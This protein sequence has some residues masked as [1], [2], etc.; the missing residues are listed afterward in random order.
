MSNRYRRHERER[1]GAERTPKQE[2]AP[3]NWYPQLQNGCS[4]FRSAWVTIQWAKSVPPFVPEFMPQIKLKM[5]HELGLA[6][7][8]LK[9]SV[10]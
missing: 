8:Q 5:G 1:A 2:S 7:I 3:F 9:R 6:L 10:C 4:I